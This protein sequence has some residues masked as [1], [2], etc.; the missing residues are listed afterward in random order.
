MGE[1]L[2][3]LAN[4]FVPDARESMS[5]EHRRAFDEADEI[6]VI[7]PTLTTRL[8]SWVSDIDGAR[9]LADERM[10]R[11][12]ADMGDAGQERAGGAV[13]DEDQVLAVADALAEFSADRLVVVVR[14]PRATSHHERGLV[15]RLRQRFALPITVVV[16]DVDGRLL[17]ETTI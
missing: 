8:Q 4:E 10:R 11:I 5:S 6:L 15:E 1:R 12:V 2:L 3:I 14:D 16:V 17:S 7:A 13:G 9:A